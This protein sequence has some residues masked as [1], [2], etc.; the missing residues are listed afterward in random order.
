MSGFAKTISRIA[1]SVCLLS[2]TAG[3]AKAAEPKDPVVTLMAVNDGVEGNS[4]ATGSFDDMLLDTI[5]SQAFARIYRMAALS[6]ELLDQQGYLTGQDEVVPSQ[7]PCEMKDLKIVEGKPV[8]EVWPV[9]VFYDVS[10]CWGNPVDMSK[11]ALHFQVVREN[12]RYVIDNFWNEGYD[13]GR[14]ETSVKTRFADLVKDNV[15]IMLRLRPG[16]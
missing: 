3:L 4:E 10:S 9:E 1:V 2:L 14:L 13:G 6:D 16:E 15:D 7:D 11:P 12:D 8:G 5:Y